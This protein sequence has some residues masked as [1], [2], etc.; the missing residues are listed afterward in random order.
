MKMDNGAHI[1][2]VLPVP[3][4][5]KKFQRHG[6]PHQQK[7]DLDNLIKSVLDALF[8]DDSHIYDLSAKKIWGDVGQIIIE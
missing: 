7:P 5:P 4:K 6:M 8:E 2:F 3:K 1:T